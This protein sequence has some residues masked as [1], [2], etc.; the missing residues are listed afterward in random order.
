MAVSPCD[1]CNSEYMC[2]KELV[3]MDLSK[4]HFFYHLYLSLNCRNV[5]NLQLQV[6]HPLHNVPPSPVKQTR[7][8]T[9]ARVHWTHTHAKPT[10]AQKQ[11][12]VQK[13]THTFT[14]WEFANL[15]MYTSSWF[16]IRF[17]IYLLVIQYIPSA[18]VPILRISEI[19]NT[20]AYQEI[21]VPL[22]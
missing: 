12:R 5:A 16:V 18:F 19:N 22:S 1:N 8:H 3:A 7:T 17:Y 11:I 20:S 4:R 9:H 21:I 13:H 10:R 6:W 2:T 14:I 15:D